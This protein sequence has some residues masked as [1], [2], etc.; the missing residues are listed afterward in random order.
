MRDLQKS[1][2]SVYCGSWRSLREVSLQ[3]MMACFP[4]RPSWSHFR[5]LHSGTWLQCVRGAPGAQ[6][7][8]EST[9]SLAQAACDPLVW[10]TRMCRTP[11]R[12]TGHRSIARL[13]TSDSV[14]DGTCTI[15]HIPL[16]W[17]DR[18][19]LSLGIHIPHDSVFC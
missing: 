4:S 3:C 10:L 16:H 14:C 6:A 7:H 8:R 12:Q 5:I 15:Q 19:P 11:A 9:V 2:L 18:R 17:P 1:V 13:T